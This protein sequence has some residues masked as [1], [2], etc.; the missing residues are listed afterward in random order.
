MARTLAVII[1]FLARLLG[2]GNVA[3]TIRDIIVRI[4]A[5]DRSYDRVIEF[6]VERDGRCCTE[7]QAGTRGATARPA[8]TTALQPVSITVGRVPP[9]STSA[10]SDG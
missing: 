8:S 4:Q 5:R 2:L 6:I 9:P 1:G 7:E 3:A 10:A